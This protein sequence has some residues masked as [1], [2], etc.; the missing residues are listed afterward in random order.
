VTFSFPPIPYRRIPPVP[1]TYLLP[2]TMPFSF[3]GKG[4]LCWQV[5]VA[6]RTNTKSYPFDGFYQGD[7]MYYACRYYSGTGCRA[8]G[9]TRPMTIG[10]NHVLGPQTGN[11]NYSAADGPP[12]RPALFTIGRSTTAYAGVPLPFA[13]PGTAGG[14]S[15][16]CTLYADLLVLLPAPTDAYGRMSTS[17]IGVP[18][19]PYLHGVSLHSQALAADPQANALGLVASDL[20]SYTFRAPFAVPPVAV[21]YQEGGP[22]SRIRLYTGRGLIVRFD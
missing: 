14:P 13:L 17:W 10:Q 19:A 12:S 7:A 16:V 15:G 9:A 1:F 18:L 8:A 2:L 21:I 6:G 3:A 4:P 22:A 5:D 11:L 20:A